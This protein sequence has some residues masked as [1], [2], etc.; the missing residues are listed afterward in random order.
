MKVKISIK[1]RSVKRESFKRVELQR[2]PDNLVRTTDKRKCAFIQG[3][4]LL[5]EKSNKQNWV[6]DFSVS[7]PFKKIS[8]FD[9]SFLKINIFK[10]VI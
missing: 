8:V 9:T 10:L 4:S 6:K 2:L 5:Q 7:I 1:I 3:I